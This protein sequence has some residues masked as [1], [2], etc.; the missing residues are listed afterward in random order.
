MHVGELAAPHLG[1]A[2]L[3]PG[4]QIDVL[5]RRTQ[6]RDLLVRHR[7]RRGVVPERLVRGIGAQAP[8]RSKVSL[9]SRNPAFTSS[10]CPRN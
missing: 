9:R 5:L 7:D 8:R 10:H 3:H 4:Q 6:T 2:V 1:V